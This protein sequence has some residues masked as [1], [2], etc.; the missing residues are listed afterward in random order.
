MTLV[1]PSIPA[2]L[3]KPAT[4]TLDRYEHL[5]ACGAFAEGYEKRVELLWGMLT[6]MA[7]IGP[8]HSDNVD[9]LADWSHEV[10]RNSGFRVRVQQ[11]IRL[12]ESNSEPEPDLAWV[13]KRSYA[14]RH[15]NPDEVLLVIEVADASLEVDRGPKLAA[16]AEA[17]LLEYWI[18]NRRERV[19]EVC[20]QPRGR[21]YADRRLAKPGEMIA[22][23]VAPGASLEVASLFEGE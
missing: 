12:P 16:Y 15:P 7:P 18:V 3:L 14:K 20:R 2:A 4:F 9:V 23:L 17:G 13:E 6:E 10:A 8:P 1:S 11:P 19:I 5:V 21:D 22:P